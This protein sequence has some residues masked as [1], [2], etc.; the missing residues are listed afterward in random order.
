MNLDII[1]LRVSHQDGTSGVIVS[2]H[3]NQPWRFSVT[4]DDNVTT[5]QNIT[6]LRVGDLP[7]TDYL[8]AR[9]LLPP[10]LRLS[11]FT[12]LDDID[13]YMDEVIAAIKSIREGTCFLDIQQKFWDKH[14]PSG[15]ES[16]LYPF[17]P[18][19]LKVKRQIW[20]DKTLPSLPISVRIE[21]IRR[22]KVKLQAREWADLVLD[23]LRRAEPVSEAKQILQ[24]VPLALRLE[25]FTS[26]DVL[27]PYKEDVIEALNG[28]QTEIG[29]DIVAI[30]LFW[31][32]H[33]P[34]SPDDFLYPLAP[35]LVQH[36]IWFTKVLPLLSIEDQLSAVGQRKSHFQRREWLALTQRIS[37][38]VPLN[39]DA[40]RLLSAIPPGI[41]M[42]FFTSLYNLDDYLDETI[43][44]LKAANK[45]ISQTTLDNFWHKHPPP[46]PKHPLY[47]LAP[48]NVKKLACRKYY[49]SMMKQISDL[50]LQDEKPPRT[51]SASTVYK[52]LAEDDRKLASLWGETGR[53]EDV[54]RLLSARAAEKVAA[55]F[56]RAVGHTVEDIAIHQ[57]DRSSQDWRTYDLLLDGNVAV[58][59]K[60]ARS[61]INNN[62]LYVEHTV[63][64]FKQDR[65]SRDVLIAG[66]LSPYLRLEYINNPDHATFVIQVIQYLGETSW[67]AIESLCTGL[68]TSKL[69][70]R[71]SAD[72]VVP[73][74]LFDYPD[75]W[76]RQFDTRSKTLR[77][78]IEWPE[79]A[80]LCALFDEHSRIAAIPKLIAAGIEPPTFF[81][82]SLDPWQRELCGKILAHASMRVPLP[83]LFLFL[84]SD[85]LDKLGDEPPTF[86]P[87]R[88]RE[89]LYA[90]ER[91]SQNS[92]VSD[93]LGLVDPLGIIDSLCTSLEILWQG[94]RSLNLSRFRSFRFS[95]LGL[96]QGREALHSPW[97]TILA[98]CGGWVY[99]RN[100]DGMPIKQGKCGYAPLIL[101][102]EHLC[103]TCHKLICG[104]CGFC[105]QSCEDQRLREAR[106]PS[107]PIDYTDS[108]NK[109]C[110]EYDK[111]TLEE[112]DEIGAPP[113]YL[114][115]SPPIEMYQNW[116]PAT[117]KNAS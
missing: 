117:P 16:R 115:E 81:S 82:E 52:N 28:V 69:E 99:K 102:Q 22:E 45:G 68:T 106:S 48:A 116:T 25:F 75:A 88:Y 18:L 21:A 79:D 90:N 89:L 23:L 1:G 8:L 77:D 83:Y 34:S 61:P 38:D 51:W 43:Q 33:S 100:D 19:Y 2:L 87:K 29:L 11:L 60:N 32:K 12:H 9:S 114:D 56:Y 71:H 86:S 78:T 109:S 74:W 5:S 44:T 10:Y 40:K 64:R 85:F 107:A 37:E 113:S 95:G 54:A 92:D 57:I 111:P 7:L 70:I 63:P 98:Y 105:S 73:P 91:G 94:R 112:G 27:A 50:F 59:V 53:P 3:P 42:E 20:L 55:S 6:S 72:R 4:F 84:L 39:P 66:I 13:P 24:S 31:K 49:A 62:N 17:S 14:C 65:Q 35:A 76:Y 58:D 36:E 26:L 30:Q 41:R 97:E 47:E 101:G 93:P 104:K 110:A 103:Q 15:P 46:N 67:P 108:T 96:L 80:E